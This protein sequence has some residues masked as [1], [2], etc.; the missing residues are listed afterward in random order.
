MFEKLIKDLRAHGYQW[1]LNALVTVFGLQILRVL[2]VS[3]VGYLR[4]SLG[5]ASLTLAPIA[6]GVFA[7]SLL[8]GPLNRLAGTRRALWITAGG[9]ALVRVAEQLA[10][11]APLDLYLSIAGTALFLMF[12]PIAIGIARAG[13]FRIVA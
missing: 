11:T 13:V 3:F 1:M 10:E 12:L 6:I 4:D 5:M 7:L 8:A 9:L 2:F